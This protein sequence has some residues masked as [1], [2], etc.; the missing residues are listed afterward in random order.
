M[1]SGLGR[2]GLGADRAL[3]STAKYTSNSAPVIAIR[4]HDG[5][6]VL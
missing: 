5:Q 2:G 4:Q 1:E 6:R 3:Q